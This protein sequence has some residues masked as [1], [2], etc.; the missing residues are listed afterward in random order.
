MELLRAPASRAGGAPA[1]SD[2]ISSLRNRLAELEKENSELK[3][4]LDRLEK[5]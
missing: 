3:A 2:D 1:N 4:R 5:K